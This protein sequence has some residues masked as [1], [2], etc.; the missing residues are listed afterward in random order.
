MADFSA[1]KVLLKEVKMK[2]RKLYAIICCGCGY[3]YFILVFEK[4]EIEKCPN[5]GFIIK[6]DEKKKSSP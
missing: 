1:K 2:K 6:F 3:H 4:P 5:C